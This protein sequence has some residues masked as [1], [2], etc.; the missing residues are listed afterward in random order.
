MGIRCIDNILDQNVFRKEYNRLSRMNV[1]ADYVRQC[2]LLGW[3]NEHSELIGGYAF[4]KGEN[5]A[6]PKLVDQDLPFFKK[7][8]PERCLEFNLAWARDPLHDRC[9][10]MISF[11]LSSRKYIASFENIDYVTFA[12]DASY[13]NLVKM[14][15]RIATETIY[16][17]AV[18]KYSDREVIIFAA[19]KHR[20]ENIFW[21]YIPEFAKRISRHIRRQF[22]QMQDRPLLQTK[23]V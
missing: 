12:V 6:W 17:G 11:W 18:A 23:E 19:P 16:R 1:P 15:E 9:F 4:A 2:L 10:D 22:R 7:I 5:M 21:I 3:Y 14:Y 8:S 13:T 20:F